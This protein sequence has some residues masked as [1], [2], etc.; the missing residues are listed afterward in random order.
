MSYKRPRIGVYVC[1]CGQNI[2]GVV[3]VKEVSEYAKTLPKVV[4]ARDH[5]YICS[6]QGQDIIAGDIEKYGLNRVVVASCSPRMH[7]KVF[8]KVLE[9]SGLSP[10]LFEMVNIREHCSWIH[11]NE[12]E[13]ATVKAKDLVRGAV[14]RA[15]LLET[16]EKS[17]EKVKKEVMVLGAG[18][19]GI[20]AALY[21]ANN[22][23]KTHLIER[24][25]SIGGHMAMLDKTFPTL[26]CG[27]CILSPK[28]VE[29]SQHENIKL[30]TNADVL[31]INGHVGDFN[32]KIRKNPRYVDKEKCVACGRCAEV[33]P[34]QGIDTF[35]CGYQTRKAIYLRYPQAVPNSYLINPYLCKYLTE[36]KCGACKKVCDRN[37]INFDDKPEE[38]EINV[39]AI[40]IATGYGLYDP[41]GLSEITKLSE[42]PVQNESE[43][44]RQYGYRKYKNVITNLDFERMINASG[45]TGGEIIRLSDNKSPTKVAFILCVGSR[46]ER[47]NA[48][49][50]SSICCMTAIKQAILIK[51]KYPETEVCIYYNDI[52]VSGRGTEEFYGRARGMG[53]IFI[54][55]LPGEIIEDSKTGDLIIVAEDMLSNLVIE[56]QVGMAILAAG[57]RPSDG[58]PEIAKKLHIPNASDG[59]ILEL[60]PK[61]KPAET[62]VDGVFVAGCAQFPKSISDTVM[63]SGNAATG[64]MEIVGKDYIEVGGVVAAVDK[65]K[66]RGCGL[67]AEVCPYDAIKIVDGVAEVEK[68]LCKGCGSCSAACLSGAIQQKHFTDKQISAQ[69]EAILEES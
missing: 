39:G 32:I 62:N 48:P 3:D 12:P 7:E 47:I 26:D 38:I 63:Q 29:V 40:I 36:G 10:Y 54:K 23:V 5:K 9:S 25:S 15:S 22:G 2:G 68:I 18:I 45:F 24:K 41:S 52:R 50:C 34:T 49:Y 67:C 30:I 4:I 6:E 8:Q 16:L 65:D 46:N 44:Q 56:N 69:V 64:A 59:F 33:C 66:C 11:P 13:K 43:A 28:M 58:T 27:L 51:E 19:A 14:A 21:L 57:M 53:V 37:A 35:N 55:G 42:K 17:E 61:L 60:H 20:F 31:N 1:Y